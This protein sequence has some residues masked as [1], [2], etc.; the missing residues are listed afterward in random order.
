MMFG[1]KVGMNGLITCGPIGATLT[2][3][4]Y[5]FCIL[6]TLNTVVYLCSEAL[7]NCNDDFTYF[8]TQYR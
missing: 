7:N 4:M 3:K 2:S 1:L 5:L 6:S 8:I